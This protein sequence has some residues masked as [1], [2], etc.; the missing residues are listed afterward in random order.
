[1]RPALADPFLAMQPIPG[2]DRVHE[3]DEDARDQ[4]VV[5][6]APDTGVENPRAHEEGRGQDD[7]EAGEREAGSHRVSVTRRFTILPGLAV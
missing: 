6:H 3:A 7:G 2:Q 1:V 5:V 4:D